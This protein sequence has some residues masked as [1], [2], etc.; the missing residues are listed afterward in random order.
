MVTQQCGS[1]GRPP[2]RSGT[3]HLWGNVVYFTCGIILMLL[4]DMKKDVKRNQH[5]T[6]KRKDEKIRDQL[7]LFGGEIA[8][9][10]GIGL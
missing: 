2:G 10:W 7:E 5:G 3:S 6:V 4:S 9:D 1:G 8:A